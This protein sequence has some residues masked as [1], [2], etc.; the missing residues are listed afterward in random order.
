MNIPGCSDRC[1]REPAERLSECP[2]YQWTSC[3][4]PVL[5]SSCPATGE[6]LGVVHAWT[7]APHAHPRPVGRP[8]Y[9]KGRS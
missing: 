1:S 9:E 4:T 7:G 3:T 5:I 2:S 8:A 6:R